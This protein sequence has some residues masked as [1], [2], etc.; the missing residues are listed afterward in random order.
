MRS[1]PRTTIVVRFAQD[2]ED[3][4]CSSGVDGRVKM[5]WLDRDESHESDDMAMYGKGET[6]GMYTRYEGEEKGGCW[7]RR[8]RGPDASSPTSKATRRWADTNTSIRQQSMQ[9]PCQ[10]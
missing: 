7:G 3:S 6:W 2:D 10:S 5:A 8:A 1:P 4:A 9:D